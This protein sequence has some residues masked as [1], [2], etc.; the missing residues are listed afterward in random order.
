MGSLISQDVTVRQLQGRACLPHRV[1]CGEVG[2]SCGGAAIVN[3]RQ[4]S[5]QLAV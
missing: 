2:Q 4:I 5:M 3:R 1:K